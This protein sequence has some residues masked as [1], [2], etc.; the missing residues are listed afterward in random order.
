MFPMDL[1]GN[2]GPTSAAFGFIIAGSR[3]RLSSFALGAITTPT[4]ICRIRL[5]SVI[6]SLASIKREHAASTSIYYYYYYY[7][8]YYQ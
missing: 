2:M 4:T 8:T 3:L 7:Y 1:S 5:I 6:G